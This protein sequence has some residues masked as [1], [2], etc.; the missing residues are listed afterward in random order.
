MKRNKL[1]YTVYIPLLGILL[2]AL[3]AACP[4]LE[5]GGIPPVKIVYYNGKFGRQNG[6]AGLQLYPDDGCIQLWQAAGTETVV[7][8]Y[9]SEDV[10]SGGYRGNEKAIM[11]EYTTGGASI[12]A[13]VATFWQSGVPSDYYVLKYQVKAE[14][15]GGTIQINAYMGT[16]ASMI[17]HKAEE[18]LIDGPV[19]STISC[20]SGWQE[21]TVPL[22]PGY[23]T[24]YIG[25]GA[26][27]PTL[28]G[29]KVLFD[30]VRLEP[31]P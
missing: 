3:F 6:H 22:T 12:W 30:N 16:M 18:V 24:T 31:K 8:D 29:I 7:G 20:N 23:V 13:I 17:D 1:L 11:L 10:G 5:S 26:N 21:R 19:S 15:P 14:G 9:V 28:P 27:N 4:N 25:L 2:L